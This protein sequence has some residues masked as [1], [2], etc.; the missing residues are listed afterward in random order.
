LKKRKIDY[1][2]MEERGNMNMQVIRLQDGE[3]IYGLLIEYRGANIVV[4][5]YLWDR[6]KKDY[7][8]FLSKN[9]SISR[10]TKYFID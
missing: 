6:D 1:R 10:S 4:D 5:Q 9:N 3:E 8:F 7:E 2:K